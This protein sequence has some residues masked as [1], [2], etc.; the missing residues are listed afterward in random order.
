MKLVLAETAFSAYT[1]KIL[2][3]PVK[4]KDEK[5]LTTRLV[6]V[7]EA[8]RW[9]IRWTNGTELDRGCREWGLKNTENYFFFPHSTFYTG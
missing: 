2:I 4:E 6:L 9:E 3:S 5:A 8:G 7:E 1:C